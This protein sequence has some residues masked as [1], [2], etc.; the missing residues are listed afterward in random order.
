MY[1]CS[2]GQ[3]LMVYFGG[4]PATESRLPGG[5]CSREISENT[6][7]LMRGSWESWRTR[8]FANGRG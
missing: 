5:E 7:A 8:W 3:A 2:V 1:C 4:S 6:S